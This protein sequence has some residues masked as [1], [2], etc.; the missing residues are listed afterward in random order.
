MNSLTA[1]PR[2]GQERERVRQGHVIGVDR[3]DAGQGNV[4]RAT[5]DF[6]SHIV[7]QQHLPG[8]LAGKKYYTPADSGYEKQIKERLQFWDDIKK[9]RKT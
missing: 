9:N 2:G 7:G 6:D 1:I 5:D 4:V 8:E 3:V